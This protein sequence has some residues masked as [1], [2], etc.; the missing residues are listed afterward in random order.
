MASLFSR[1]EQ[2]TSAAVDRVYGEETRIV[3]MTRGAVFASKENS[4]AQVITV[5]GVIDIN[6]VAIRVQDQSGFDGL[7]P[8]F[9][10]E[11]IHVSY[12]LSRFQ[13]AADV[14]QKDWLIV[15]SERAEMPKYRVT[16]VDPDG[17]GRIVCVCEP[18]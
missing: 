15:A 1:L 6:P 18:A 2:K 7:M 12:D 8:S 9:A 16:R 3:P 14:P 5:L 17:I 4:D 10:G 11:K 13:N